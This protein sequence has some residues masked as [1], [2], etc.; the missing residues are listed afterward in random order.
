MA[1]QAACIA[2]CVNTARG[3]F[4]EKEMKFLCCKGFYFLCLLIFYGFSSVYAISMDVEQD[5]G[6]KVHFAFYRGSMLW[7]AV[8]ASIYL[9]FFKSV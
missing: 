3:S 9:I 7:R 2:L 5:S 6:L 8:P 1:W 4:E